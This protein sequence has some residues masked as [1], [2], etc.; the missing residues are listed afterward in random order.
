[1]F[2]SIVDLESGKDA[3]TSTSYTPAEMDRIRVETMHVVLICAQTFARLTLNRTK[4]RI[5]LMESMIDVAAI[6]KGH[7]RTGDII[8]KEESYLGIWHIPGQE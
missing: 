8:R 3:T 1:M 2:L 5:A 4:S 6:V 7:L